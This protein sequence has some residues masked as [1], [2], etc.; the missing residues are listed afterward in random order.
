MRLKHLL[1]AI[2]FGTI[3]KSS[4]LTAQS[5][6]SYADSL[7]G[8]NLKNAMA[9]VANEGLT[10]SGLQYYIET[11]K[12]LYIDQKYQIGIFANNI[13]LSL[14]SKYSHATINN[15][16][17]V[18][19]GFESGNLSGW[20][21]F[22]GTN[23][24]SQ[25]YPTTPVSITAGPIVSVMTT[26]FTDPYV[27]PTL[28]V[29]IP[30][31]PFSGNRVVRINNNGT[32]AVNGR[33][34]VKLL[35][36]FPVTSNNNIFNFAYWVVFENA[37]GHNC[38]ETPFM[39]V[40]LRS[41]PNA[42]A[43]ETCPVFSI[44][45]PS[46]STTAQPTRTCVGIGPAS[47]TNIPAPSGS[48]SVQT[49]TS[50][51]K[52]AIN[53]T[54][55]IGQNVQI[56]V[57]VGACSLNGHFGY[58]Y[59]DSDCDVL[60]LG[61]NTS[62]ISLQDGTV[63]AVGVCGN[64]ATLTAP[65][66]L[67]PYLW[68]G[69]GGFLS[70]NQVIV[71]STPG[72]YTLGLSPPGA[73]PST[74]NR[75]INLSF[76]PQTTV[77]ASPST[78]CASG[79]NSVSILSASGA[80]N[81]TWQP[82][83]LTTSTIAASP[84]ITQIYT[85]TAT[86][87]SCTG[88][89]TTQV[90]VSADPTVTISG[91]TNICGGATASLCAGNA[92]TY[93][94]SPGGATGSC[95]TFTPVTPTTYTVVGTSSTGCIDSETITVGVTTVTNTQAFVLTGTPPSG[96]FCVNSPVTLIAS[97]SNGS[98]Y[99]WTPGGATGGIISVT[100]TITTT[101]TVTAFIGSC[102]ETATVTVNVDRGPT[103]TVTASPT[104][105]PG[106]TAT[107][108]ANAPAA[109]GFTWAP[110]GGN[111]S[112]AAVSPTITTTYSVTGTNSNTC[113]STYTV[114][115][116]VFP[117]PNIT[118]NPTSPTLCI[119][120]TL[121]VT[122][123]GGLTYT[124]NPGN[125]QSSLAALSPTTNT[126]YTVVSSNGNCTNSAQV[127]LTVVNLPL[128]GANVSPI[129][130]CAGQTATL[131]GSGGVTYTWNPGGLT[132]VNPTVSPASTTNYTVRGTSASGCTNTAVTSLTVNPLPVLSTTAS[133]GAICVGRSSTLSVS[134]GSTYLWVPG[135]LTGSN[136]T[137]SP[138]I[139]T[140]Y[141]V[142]GTSSAG[143]VS[144]TVR[145]VTV[146]PLPAFTIT[147]PSICAGR[148]ATL[149]AA[150]TATGYVWN[151]G[152]LTGAV[153]NPTPAAT[154]VYTVVGTS[155]SGCTAQATATQVVVPN[156]TVLAGANPTAICIGSAVTLTA[157]GATSYVWNPGALTGTSISRTPTINTTY[158][159]VGTS[160]GCTGSRTVAVIVNPLPTLT[161]S[162]S[163]ASVCPGRSSTLTA[164]GASTYSWS[165]IATTGSTANV[166]PT[167][168]TTYTASGTSTAGCVNT[169]TVRVTLNAA[170]TISISNASPTICAGRAA[171]LTATGTSTGYVWNPGNLT[172][173]AI[174]P[175]PAANT[176]YTVVGTSALGCTNQAQTSVTVVP[177][178]TVIAGA[179]PNPV[180]LGGVVTLTATGATTYSWNPGAFIGTSFTPTPSTN[181][182]YTV[183]GNTAG[184]TGSAVV[185]V[186]VNPLP[187]LSLSASPASVCPGQSSTLT[188][189]GAS[190]Y[191]WS[192]IA[193][194]GTSANV[195]PSVTTIYTVSGTST[196]GCVNTQTVRVTVNSAPTISISNA[197][198]TIC[199]GR[200]A[201]LTAS[202]TSTG[203]VW[204]P[205][206][207]TTA[208][209][210][211]TPSTTTNYTVIGTSAQGCTNQAQSTVS[212]TPNPTV[213]ATANPTA[214]CLSQNAV[215]TATGAAGY[216]WTPGG[217]TTN[218]FTVSPTVTTTYSVQGITAG[219]TGSAVVTLVVNPLPSITLTATQ[220][221]ICPGQSATLSASGAITYTYSSGSPIV[222]PT[223][224]TVYT[225][226]GT[227]ATGCTNTQTVQV[228]V[229]PVPTLT[230][231]NSTPTICAGSSASLTA[232]GTA[233]GYV[234]NPGALTGTNVTP[235][236]TSTTVY[237][238]TGT[239]T[240]GCTV[241]AQTTV[242]VIPNPVV[243]ATAVP[244]SICVGGTVSL[245]ANGATSYSWNPGALT[246]ATVTPS[247]TI[248]TTYT[249]IGTTAGCTGSAVVTV[250]V[251]PLP[252][253]TLTATQPSICP[254]QS[255]TLSA[256]GAI[257]YTYSSGSPIVSPTVTT[258]YTATG[259]SATGCTNTQ[260]VQ[261]TVNPVPTLTITN[262]TP[263]IC[264]GSSASLTAAG[265]A[266][267]YV[268][269]PGALTGTNVTP[270]PTS[271][272]V[273]T[274]TG[275][276]TS[277][278]TVQ[279]QT[280]VVVIP[281]P[282]VT[283]TAV[284]TSICVGGTVSLRA[285][286]ATSYSWNPGALTGATVTPSPTINTTYTLIGTTAGCT[287]SAVVTVTVNPLPTITLTATQPSICPGQSATL[288]ASGASTYTY[289]SGSPIV[290]PTITTVYTATGTSAAGCTN[291]QT[292]QVTVNP[293]PSITL[294]A[295]Q[296]SICPGGTSTLS[297][298]GANTYTY[299]SGS[300]IVSPTITTVY[301]A[302][303]TS[304]A[305]CTST[306]TVQVTV[307]SIPTLT[308]TN[309]T[310]T[311][312]VGQT[313]TLGTTGSFTGTVWQPSGSTNVTLNPSPLVTT[314][315]TVVAT[316]ALG[317][318]NQAQ[319]TVS[320]ISLPNIVANANPNPIC[321]GSVVT[322]TASGASSYQWNPGA[323][324]GTSVVVSPTVNT[325]YTVNGTSSGCSASL[326]ISV[327]VNPIPSVTASVSSP[328]I[329]AGQTTSLV[330]FG[331]TTYSWNPIAQSGNSVAITPTV[332]T[333]YT[334]FGTSLGCVGTAT[335][336][337]VVNTVPIITATATPASLC[338]GNTATLSANGALSYAWVPGP[339]SGNNVT[340]SPTVNTPYIVTGTNAAGCTNSQTVTVT[341]NTVPT[342]SIS[343]STNT[344]C[345]GASATLTASG[346]L[347]YTWT[348]GNSTQT[349]IV[350]SPSVTTV[351]TLT[352]SN[353]FGCTNVITHTINVNSTPTVVVSASSPTVCN[354]F[355]TALIAFG[356]NTYTWQPGS[357]VGGTVVVTPTSNTTYT[358][359][360]DNLGCTSNTILPIV[361][362]PLPVVTATASPSTICIGNTSTLTAGGLV[363]Y[364][365][366]PSFATGSTITDTPTITSTYTVGGFGINGCPNFTTVSITVLQVP[367]VTAV[368]SATAIC[369]GSTAA[370]TPTGAT[371]YTVNPGNLTGTLITVSPVTTTTYTV[372]GNNATCSNS[373]TLAI[374]VNAL[375]TVSASSTPTLLCAGG[376]LTLSGGGAN[377]YTWNPSGLVGSTVV[378]NPTITTTYT[379]VGEDLNGC[380]NTATWNVSVNPLPTFTMLANPQAT[381]CAG[382]SVSILATSPALTFT[383]NPTGLNTSSI[384]DTPTTSTTYSVS[385]TDVNGCVGTETLL[386]S[387]VPLPT[388][389]ISPT[390]AT[391]CSG[392]PATLTANGALNYT[393]LPS[394]TIGSVTI[395][396]PTILTTYTVIADNG[397]NCPTTATVDVNI[398]SLP[399]ITASGTPTLIC[400]GAPL[401]LT[402]GGA[403]NYTW[404][405]SAQTGS[406]VVDNP[407]ITTT[408]TVSGEDANGCV[409]TA[410]WTANV[411]PL[412]TI[413]ITAVPQATIC[414]GASVT[415]NANSTAISYTWSPSGLSANSIT[416][417]P[418][419]NSTYTVDGTDVNG[420]IGTQTIQVSVV[421]L[422]TVTISPTNATVCAGSTVALTATGASNY[423]WLPS[424]NTGSTTIETP[425]VLT[426]YTVIADNGGNCPTT[427]TVDVAVN[428]LPAN[429][430]ASSSG[431]ISC[432]SQIATLTGASTDTNVSF[433][434]SGPSGFNSSVQNPTV[435]TWGDFTLTVTDN[436][437]GCVSTAT[438]NVP[439]DNS[440]PSPTAA[441]SGSITC[442]VNSVTISATHTTT[443]PAF[444]W[445]GPSA[446]TSTLQ[447]DVVTVAGDYTITI[448][449]LS[450]SCTGTAIVTVGSHTNVQITASI[451]PATCSLG[452]T[453]N[454]GSII[455]TGYLA[456]D[457]FDL[458]T[459][460]T[461]TG[462]ATY[463]S[464][465][466]IPSTG[467][468]TNNL[469][470]PTTTLAFTL[471]LFD[472]EGCVKDTVLYLI[473]ID[474]T[475]KILGIAKAITNTVTNADGSYD[476]GYKIVVKNYDTAPLT[477]V[478]LIENLANTFPAPS[479]FTVVS[480]PVIASAGSSLVLNSGFDGS[481]QT[482]ITNSTLSQL[483][484][485]QSDTI[486]FTV[487]VTV[488]GVFGPFKNTVTSTALYNGNVTV[489]DS[490]HTGLNPDPDADNNP[491]NNS[492]STDLILSP[493]LFFGIT[494]VGEFVQRA[495]KTFDVT[496]TVTVHN[497]GNDTLRNVIIKDSLFAN[498]VK[499]PATYVIKSAPVTDGGL[500]ANSAFDGRFDI[501]LVSSS[502]KLNPGASNN[503]VFAIN[504]KGDTLKET[505][506]R[507]NAFGNAENLILN[508]SGILVSDTSNAGTN[509]DSNN[510]GVWNESEDN[511]PTVI[512][513]PMVPTVTV[514][515]VATAT[516]FIPEGFS[517][518]GDGINDVFD[519]KGLPTNSDNS[520]IIFNRWGNR[521]YI[522]S[523]YN[524][525]FDG[526]PNVSGAFGRD[527]VPP[528]TY[529][530][531][532][533]MKSNGTKTGFIVIQY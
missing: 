367:T 191:S 363:T 406:Q 281:N 44:V 515:V 226:T 196:A 95:T 399:T 346:T 260:T 138:T 379:L 57:V 144:N 388:V 414:I 256:S 106:I 324:T 326:A 254:G 128:I 369:I 440:I 56:E 141:T 264:A 162:A 207:L 434:W 63:S 347:A 115:Q 85:V 412:P 209:I 182:S 33:R 147:S 148:V 89:F 417:T 22:T 163:P 524:G 157:T 103:M 96:S 295:T 189:S 384:T 396:T 225:A 67:G 448:T 480:A 231:T 456:A 86:T 230:I 54:G 349:S 433:A 532:L 25:V 385:G 370:I 169:Q 184:C 94:W 164:S 276:N 333:T 289:S 99:S 439:T 527:K 68:S 494:K 455:V 270:T 194:T 508:G 143:C 178:P 78:I 24:N 73:C 40:R 156:P 75:Y 48:G 91:P 528:G 9:Q 267:G 37:P 224:T 218:L 471:R 123:L 475:P 314:S 2:L 318:T 307:N 265:T 18:N 290:S 183:V 79:S 21:A 335:T 165:P 15:A 46:T 177:N 137:V 490:S 390:N 432:A 353:G 19:E 117:R 488:N 405:P 188:A 93:V 476:V 252:T 120:R 450:S 503:I 458:V 328:T 404:N 72:T 348:P 278:C 220:P 223:V 309:F 150:G 464:A 442:S 65:F 366:L 337:V 268:W 45:A 216:I 493:K 167:I 325:T 97:S 351:Y 41:A 39:Q 334:V 238:L 394:G 459:G 200:A 373:T 449:D 398:Y 468:I 47:W 249:V 136:V 204:N 244:T 71:R 438:V 139:N 20:S 470:N 304:A 447:N 227:S 303:G 483:P 313:A 232:A 52:F 172:T 27:F 203:Y 516:L 170:P 308:L 387:V 401:T 423:T 81:Y 6:P 441:V 175:T 274:L 195:T 461:Y 453:N 344:I 205:G 454:D 389:N 34:A 43:L 378:D 484:G 469:A 345:S 523:N 142:T 437:T 377:S 323:L 221:S 185:N 485:G 403:I 129:A 362:N 174:N 463:T 38:S 76:A 356:A 208:I 496:Y 466:S 28:G 50:W 329:C 320:V 350:V 145:T 319:T 315:Y 371:S 116:P 59:F 415:L 364:T 101:Y 408:Y 299:S 419:T 219:C 505:I 58:A 478:S 83:G 88:T 154:T 181:T 247:P 430:T 217:N 104:I 12:R 291:T 90:N 491:N 317:C 284:P 1:F 105:C 11:E 112:V 361:V 292:V 17:C 312:C 424:G 501:N 519:I 282:V 159:V 211:P 460:N 321:V 198:P 506:L 391:V 135:S 436:V 160:A 474:C 206:G 393:W 155:A 422:P 149:T 236:P 186:T 126:T 382:S 187:T 316:S 489:R 479:T 421:P 114:S 240:S 446:F 192:P 250:T 242:V 30:A 51:Q 477:E 74:I 8:F 444:S 273:Y 133:P 355:T 426:N 125:I 354:G 111:A 300:P 69:P 294:T 279:A 5:I 113:R 263:T 322:L 239:N 513:L 383:W 431:T 262:S 131:N 98:S 357:L 179:N 259:T 87:G 23:T 445:S 452:V 465:V 171:T 352:G 275:T 16:P 228:T 402:A 122:A 341:V 82:G 533:D 457:K 327:T 151:P 311:L 520:I 297:A 400:G 467:I 410:T 305:G 152:A 161:L 397:G 214:I 395:E 529:Y 84:T 168:T 272:T 14:N 64:S 180:C 392:S 429:V 526:T 358:V 481:G 283:A 166:T 80:S 514:P 60:Q 26:P 248:N 518:N 271:T 462:T 13:Q 522:H 110:S 293:I 4:T 32:G 234:W 376:T 229:N 359:T 245:R 212:V 425:I 473:P 336:S 502:S 153:I 451:A 360:G 296:P 517:P 302:T 241:Q 531:I 92:S 407:T 497:R 287:G 146:N 443:N 331:A 222:S 66:G 409:N 420:C 29:Q 213:G 375:P 70:T 372:I 261:V 199:A 413:T 7:K 132:G 286:G 332:N 107:L 381:V 100:P 498:V 77:T 140:T 418:L 102:S 243:T 380:V 482:S 193:T 35:Q 507:N 10:P 301:T 472:G 266:T 500:I 530:Y 235:T 509:P 190:T 127:T 298:S 210:N 118:F 343:A 487:R 108:T 411:N 510:N 255:A 55:Y 176:T 310:P 42:S 386:I 119:G 173:A 499:A 233:T 197:S 62:T 368:S 504:V 53:L 435:N 342:L 521:V 3:Y 253:I 512:I 201:T 49:N 428:P 121:S 280:T 134:G 288:S 339:L 495:D 258:V 277:G 109:T 269:N 330:A 124:W 492:N 374:V 61:V 251:N 486:N 306:Q 237:T 215:L 246:G 511:L 36:S 31:S 285:N 365:W 257:T 130:I 202:G 427:L 340:V 416:D 338:L 525:G 158:T